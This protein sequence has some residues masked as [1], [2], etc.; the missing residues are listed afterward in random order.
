MQADGR[1]GTGLHCKDSL[2]IGGLPV[3]QRKACGL[4]EANGACNGHAL[5]QACGERL[6]CNLNRACDARVWALSRAIWCKEAGTVA[7]ACDAK[8]KGLH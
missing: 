3:L 2:C 8:G 6:A 7:Q 4:E 5:A 1:F